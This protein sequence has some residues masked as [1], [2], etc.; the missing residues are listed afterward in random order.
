M[1]LFSN[2]IIKEH[3]LT[4]NQETNLN[5]YNIMQICLH[6]IH[7]DVEL[8]TGIKDNAQKV[9]FNSGAIKALYQFVFLDTEEANLESKEINTITQFIE[10]FPD[11][12]INTGKVFEIQVSNKLPNLIDRFMKELQQTISQYLMK[13]TAVLDKSS[14]KVKKSD[15]TKKEKTKDENSLQNASKK[16]ENIIQIAQDYIMMNLYKKLFP[17]KPEKE[18]VEIYH[19]CLKLSWITFSHVGLLV[20][21]DHFVPFA[22]NLMEQFHSAKLP[23][24]KIDI[25][26]QLR[27]NML[28]TLNLHVGKTEG[29]V[30]EVLP[31][32]VFAIIKSKPKFL[33]SNINFI[34][35]YHKQSKSIELNSDFVLLKLVKD[36][37]RNISHINL[38]NV[39]EQ[40]FSDNCN[41]AFEKYKDSI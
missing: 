12:S 36:Y 11:L 31:C 40:E 6:N 9:V 27:T 7:F 41:K 3:Q 25:F 5:Q 23:H 16:T 26:T 35:M 18:D 21:V 30:D 28:V 4:T 37:I 32:L 29:S 2:S 13:S 22:I 8:T 17:L 14:K 15:K 33:S 34:Q 10:D 20:N 38:I 24:Q 19:K 39:T 1:Q